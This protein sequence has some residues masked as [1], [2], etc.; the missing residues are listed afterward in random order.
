ME[1]TQTDHDVEFDGTFKEPTVTTEP[2]NLN[3]TISYE[4]NII[5][6]IEPVSYNFFTVT[7]DELNFIGET[8][9]TLTINEILGLTEEDMNNS[10]QAYPNPAPDELTLTWE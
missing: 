3:Y 6:P 1:Q 5:A 8:N 7:I 10:M 4:G 9:G 2:A